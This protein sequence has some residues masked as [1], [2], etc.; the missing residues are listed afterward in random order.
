MTERGGAERER[1]DPRYDA[2]FQ[3]GFAGGVDRVR[4]DERAF[5]R[6]GTAPEGIARRRPPALAD[7]ATTADSRRS[8]RAAESGA[9][10]SAPARLPSD[11]A[12]AREPFADPAPEEAAVRRVEVAVEPSAPLWRNP[13]LLALLLAGL[14]GSVL[15]V[16]LLYSGYSSPPASYYGDSDTPSPEWIQRQITYY[17]SIPLLGSLPFALLLA[18]GVA[19]LRWRAR[20]AKQAPS[21]DVET[22]SEATPV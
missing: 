1:V 21:D 12:P 15:G 11:A 18:M 13:W 16:A 6:P 4:G 14:A 7:I 19:A 8:R 9:P 5:A 17:A 22:E 3:R 10:I 20:P 2:A